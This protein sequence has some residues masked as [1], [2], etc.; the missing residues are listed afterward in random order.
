MKQ[1]F[2]KLGL[3]EG[4]TVIVHSSLSSLGWVV[5][6]AVAVVQALMDVV[7]ETGTIV[8]P[9]H[10]AELSDPSEWANPP[11]PESWWA[12]IREEMPA[13]HPSYTPTFYMGKIAETF[14]TFPGVVRSN[15]PFVSFAAW[16]KLSEDITMDHSLSYGLGE[17]SPL[18]RLYEYDGQVLL[19]GVGYDNNTSFHLGE[20]HAPHQQQIVRSA[21]IEVRGQRVWKRYADIEYKDELFV[22]I[23]QDFEE[24]HQVRTGMV[25]SATTKLFGARDA[26]DFCQSWLREKDEMTIKRLIELES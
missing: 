8:M 26:V 16:G 13:F 12:T 3:K 22:Q 25:G 20:H 4:S 21:P 9:T 18:G 11:V 1:E 7:E 23:G 17:D 5:G 14:R 6:G 24:H 19:L 10:T 2:R 15:H